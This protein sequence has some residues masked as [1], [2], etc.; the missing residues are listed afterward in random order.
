[1]E[2]Q[3]AHD[4]AVERYLAKMLEDAADFVTIE[5]R[6]LEMD[7]FGILDYSG[8]L[9]GSSLQELYPDLPPSFAA[10]E[11]AWFRMEKKSP[12]PGFA[13]ALIGLKTG[14]SREVTVTF[15]TTC[16]EEVLRE[17]TV[18]YAVTLHEIKARQLPPLDD[19]FA[20]KLKPGLTLAMLK[21]EVR[22][23]LQQT[24]DYHFRQKAQTAVVEKLLELNPCEPPTAMVEREKAGILKNII[25]DNQER[26]VPE[27]TIK[28]HQEELMTSANKS[29]EEKV[30]LHF[31]LNDIAEKEKISITPEEL[32]QQ[33]TAL[34]QR[35]KMS[36]EKLLKE[37]KKNRALGAIQE[38]MIFTKTLQWLVD[39]AS[40]KELPVSSSGEHDCSDH[41]HVHG[42]NCQH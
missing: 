39:H 12:F 6:G 37:L 35:Y 41:D 36:V 34:S 28:S 4:D 17:A 9:K 18:I 21:K 11:H 14:E 5:D 32:Q 31:L 42:P 19:A 38:E 2:K 1:V 7:D 29:A 10:R 30:K 27:E 16:A 15:P 26:G 13:E 23:Y 20:D 3:I 24:M 40:I 25:R 33:I 22:D 8:T